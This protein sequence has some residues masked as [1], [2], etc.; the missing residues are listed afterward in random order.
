MIASTVAMYATQSPYIELYDALLACE[1]REAV[2]A[3]LRG[4]LVDHADERIWIE[5]W[6]AAVATVPACDDEDLCRLY[7][8]SRVND[9]LLLGLQPPHDDYL[10]FMTGLGMRVVTRE[11]FHPYFHEIVAIEASPDSSAPP[12]V[13]REIWPCLV[14]GNLLF[15][16]AGCAL[17]AGREHM[18][19]EIAASTTLY[20]T[21][22]RNHRPVQDL[23]AGWGHNSQWRTRF[24][25]DYWLGV[26]LH[27]N[28]DAHL[29]VRAAQLTNPNPAREDLTAEERVELLTHRCFVRTRKA[30]D[31]LWPYD[32]R[33][34]ERHL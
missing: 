16:R 8:L 19:P 12:R 7:G 4:W 30:H 23:S 10:G 18:D 5:R 1:T 15:S 17:V 33:L 34:V 24:R 9:L 13:Q 11:A 20:W 31:E 29:D 32:D 28:V 26:S 27:Y 25:R 22:R 6:S 3:V 2:A 21:H 14:L